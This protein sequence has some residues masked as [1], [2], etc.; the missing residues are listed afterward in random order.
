MLAILLLLMQYS[1]IGEE[2]HEILGV[3]MFGLFIFHQILNR[4]WY[5][6]LRVGKFNR[7]RILMTAINFL[8][9]ILMLLQI[10]SGFI[11][12]NYLFHFG[13][14]SCAHTARLIHL[15]VS[16]WLFIFVAIHLGLN[17][18]FLKTQLKIKSV[19]PIKILAGAI[20]IYGVYAFINRQLLDYMILKSEFVFLDFSENVVFVIADFLSIL[21]LF[22]SVGYKLKS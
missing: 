21:I 20:S 17:F 1:M 9:F 12:S 14:Y 19:L 6:S 11:L 15:A 16:Y 10:A 22:S 18:K 13:F 5:K 2:L 4:N 7:D 3:A 8:I